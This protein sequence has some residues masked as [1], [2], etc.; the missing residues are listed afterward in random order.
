MGDKAKEKIQK[1]FIRKAEKAKIKVNKNNIH[2][3]KP[4][5]SICGF[6]STKYPATIEE[7][8]EGR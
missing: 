8:V 5:K 7:L 4:L 6:I 3:A 1:E 2:R